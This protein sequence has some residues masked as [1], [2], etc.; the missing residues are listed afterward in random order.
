MKTN[1]LNIFVSDIIKISDNFKKKLSI[2]SGVFYINNSKEIIYSLDN[3]F[4]NI[5]N[6]PR[7]PT[8]KVS[9]FVYKLDHTMYSLCG[10]IK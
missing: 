5:N 7:P 10:F 9:P 4:S 2:V 3:L 1:I 8:K 6:F